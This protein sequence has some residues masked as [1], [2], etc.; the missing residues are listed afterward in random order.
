MVLVDDANELTY[1]HLEEN[2]ISQGVGQAG[3]ERGDSLARPAPGGMEVDH[4]LFSLKVR[5][6]KKKRRQ[7]RQQQKDK[8][9]THKTKTKN[10]I[11]KQ[12]IYIYSYI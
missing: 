6:T 3:Q 12:K 9:H 8:R 4:H 11:L 5:Y 10:E 2:D 1:S 7:K